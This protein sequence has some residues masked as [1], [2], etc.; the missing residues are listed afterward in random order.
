MYTLREG[1]KRDIC[2]AVE[3][4]RGSGTI[5]LTSPQRR[6]L[7][8]NRLLIASYD[9]GS[10]T[11]DSSAGELYW[12]FDSTVAALSIVG[13]YYVQFRGTIGTELYEREVT[14]QVQEFGP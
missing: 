7:D 6:V 8:S 13:T 10:A 4:L 3:R 5:T 9:W 12:T 1:E 14:V 2:V 11:W